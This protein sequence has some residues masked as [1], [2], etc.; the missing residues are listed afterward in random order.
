MP[1]F[2]VPPGFHENGI[3]VGME[4]QLDEIDQRLFHN[5]RDRGTAT[6]LL[7]G[8]A[9]AGKSHIARQ[10]VYNNRLK[11]PGGIFWI[12]VRSIEEMYNEIW[13]IAQKVVAKD[14][15]DLRLGYDRG[16][17]VELVK[18]W[19]E[20]RQEWLI[21]LDGIN[22]EKEEDLRELQKIIPNAPNSSIIYCSR[23]R[24]LGS[25][26]RLLL[27]HP[28]KVPKLN[29]KEG[30]ELLFREI[31]IT[32]PKA[33]ELKKASKLVKDVD[34]LPLAIHAIAARLA[35]TQE[36][37]ERFS[38]KS[39]AQ[40]PRLGSTYRKIIDDLNE[41][42]KEAANLMNLIC[43]FGP[44]IPVEMIFLGL[45]A[46]QIEGVDVK[47]GRAGEQPDLNGSFVILIRN[48][49]LERNEQEDPTSATSSRSS[50]LDPEPM[51]VLKI[52][53]VIQKFCRDNLKNT[54]L[55][56]LWL[57]YAVKLFVY[58]FR[59]ADRK[60]KKNPDPGTARISD[61]RE[62]LIHGQSLHRHA[63]EYHLKPGEL[64]RIKSELDPVIA[65]IKNE[66]LVREPGSSQE[67]VVRGQFQ[68]SV[69]DRTS[70]NSS[71]GAS[72]SS[73][74]PLTP[75]EHRLSLSI[76]ESIYG[77]PLEQVKLSFHY[78]AAGHQRQTY[79]FK[80]LTIS[81]VSPVIVYLTGT[82]VSFEWA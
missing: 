76:D 28:I 73:E 54:N 6:C 47:S 48:A 68:V 82:H 71:S 14:S 10:Y 19:F 59:V 35:D 20:N 64:D 79:D 25:R 45:R 36:P 40:D 42:H 67:S 60:I 51:D 31:G 55:L 46:L 43:F 38:F 15:P 57:L 77:V 62:Y 30:Q 3:F 18:D 70:S 34:G 65:D 5:R 32:N 72:G 61:Y 39:Y 75:G 33:S 78:L 12:N 21:V 1:F 81:I 66:I 4:N 9:G 23:S 74:R 52:H 37:L 80:L 13:Q 50:L 22:D 29:T 53:S 44:H 2:F 16:S 27:P 49:L 7:H 41:L 26:Q 17:F 63:E 11:F 24:R 69:F 58:S 56:P 8:A